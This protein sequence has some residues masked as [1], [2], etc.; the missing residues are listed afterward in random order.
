MSDKTTSVWSN[1]TARQFA[2]ALVAIDDV[3][4]LQSFLRDVMTEKEIIEISSRLEVAR[5]LQAGNKYADIVA[6]TKLSS[7]TVARISDW[8]QNGS[9]GYDAVLGQMSRQDHTPPA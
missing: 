5:L 4:L 9:D 1:K 3:A 6:E 2:E 7:R 8:M